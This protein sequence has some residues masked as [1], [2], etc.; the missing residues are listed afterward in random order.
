[1]LLLL[2]LLA[3]DRRNRLLVLI[4]S[5]QLGLAQNRLVRGILV[6]LKG[7]PLLL[8]FSN[9]VSAAAV[10]TVLVDQLPRVSQFALQPLQLVMLLII[11]ANQLGLIQAVKLFLLFQIILCQ[12]FDQLTVL[13]D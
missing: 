12:R 1:M 3:L 11:I 7:R 8:V 10:F 2:L 13:T 4:I 5:N 6:P 9:S